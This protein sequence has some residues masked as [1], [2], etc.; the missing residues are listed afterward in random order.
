MT[1]TDEPST[2][3]CDTHGTGT[4]CC[5]CCHLNRATD[6]ALGFVEN[7]SDPQ[8]LQAWCDECEQMFL[9]EQDMTEAFREFNGLTIVCDAC[10][11]RLKALHS[12]RAP[13]P[14]PPRKEG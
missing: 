5:I 11:H 8:D 7:S 6:M 2:V 12:H 10:Y 14:P 13:A 4:P 3:D 1:D 9:R